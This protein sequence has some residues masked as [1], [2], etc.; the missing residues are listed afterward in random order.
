MEPADGTLFRLAGW[1][2]V[3]GGSLAVVGA[4]WPPHRQWS[5]PLEE[6][7][8]PFIVLGVQLVR[9]A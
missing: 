7:L 3:A 8:R 9:R 5:A 2:L 1:L 6:G 4:F